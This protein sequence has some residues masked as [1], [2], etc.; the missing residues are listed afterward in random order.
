MKAS[1]C[2]WNALTV[3][4]LGLSLAA[5]AWTGAVFINPQGPLNP[6]KPLP[7]DDA[8]L[9]SEPGL[10]ATPTELIEFP[11]LPPEWTATFTPRPTASQTRTPTE[12][13]TPEPT[14]TV[15]LS[16]VGPTATQSETPLPTRTPTRTP[17]RVPPS[18]TPGSYPA[19]AVLPP[20]PTDAPG[21]P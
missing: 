4:F 3:V 10:V 7:L 8:S 17:A 1:G 5:V 2:L 21:Y 19:T 14:A 6:L 13:D 9:P 18:A 12:T 15:D 20:P 16:P 11:T